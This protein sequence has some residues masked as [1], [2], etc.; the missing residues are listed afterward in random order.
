MWD[1]HY[2]PDTPDDPVISEVLDNTA[3]PAPQGMISIITREWQLIYRPAYHGTRLYRWPT[4]P[5]EQQD[6]SELPENQAT[7]ERLKAEII[8]GLERSYRPWRDT[9]YLL[10]LSGP[11]FSPDLEA[12]QPVQLAPGHSLFQPD[13]GAVQT[14][15]PPNPETPESNS[16]HPDE[17]LIKSIPYG[18]P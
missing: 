17:D 7:V 5:L 12:L 10:A 4:D 1:P 8:S 13:A 14:L 11:D 16:K 3:L 9:R 2:E 18:A 15:F 6:V